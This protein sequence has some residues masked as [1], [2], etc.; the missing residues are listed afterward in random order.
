MQNLGTKGAFAPRVALA[1]L[2]GGL[3]SA[4]AAPNTGR[5]AKAAQGCN[6]GTL[7]GTYAATFAGIGLPGAVPL[8][9]PQRVDHFFPGAVNGLISF[10][11][12]GSWSFAGTQNFGGTYFPASYNGGYVVHTNCTGH[13]GAASG[14]N[15]DFVVFQ[16]GDRANAIDA[17]G[18]VEVSR[19][20]RIE[21]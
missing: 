10:D 5:L 14:I 21:Q 16:N 8:K 20:E 9:K 11:G 15:W 1:I 19:L 18:S 6:N 2:I 7:R 3:F 4:I 12:Q 13:F 17:S